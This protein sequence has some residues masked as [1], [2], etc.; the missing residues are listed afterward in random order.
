MRSC[1]NNITHDVYVGKSKQR[2]KRAGD[3]LQEG[4]GGGSG[5]NLIR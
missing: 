3:E 2:G 5:K 4:Q 1:E